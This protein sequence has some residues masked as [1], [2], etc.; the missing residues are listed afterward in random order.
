MKLATGDGADQYWPIPITL[1]TDL[2]CGPGDTIELTS[3]EGKA[4]GTLQVEEVFDRDL[5]QEA[6]Q[7][8]RPRGR[9]HA[10]L[11]HPGGVT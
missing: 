9:L 2:D 11:P 3:D 8:P 6:E 10:P 4:L 1:P 5:E 7:V